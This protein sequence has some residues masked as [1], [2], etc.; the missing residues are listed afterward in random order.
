M[1]EDKCKVMR[2]VDATLLPH[3]TQKNVESKNQMAGHE[4]E[5]KGN[6]D[7]NWKNNSVAPT[8]SAMHSGKWCGHEMRGTMQERLSFAKRVRRIEKNGTLKDG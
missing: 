1:N 8:E 5:G 4:P 3:T 2:E 7:C 6:R